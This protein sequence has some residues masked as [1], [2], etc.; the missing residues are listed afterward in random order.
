L[1]CQPKKLLGPIEQIANTQGP[2]AWNSLGTWEERKISLGELSSI[3]CGKVREFMGK[4]CFGEI[5]LTEIEL[6]GDAY[7]VYKKNKWNVMYELN[8]SIKF[9]DG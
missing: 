4:S 3:V 7:K 6:D 9:R 2:S 8:G 5:G 1:E